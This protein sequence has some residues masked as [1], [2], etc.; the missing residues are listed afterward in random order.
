[1]R[2]LRR[3]F[4]LLGCALVGVPAGAASASAAGLFSPAPGELAVARETPAAA[5]LPDGRVLVA[6]GFGKEKELGSAEIYDPATGASEA[7]AAG[8]A[9]AHGE[10]ATVALHDGRVL[11]IGGWTSAA[12]ALRSAEVFDPVTRTFAALGAEM[13]VERD[14]PAAVVLPSG[15]V[16]IT[17][18]AQNGSKPYGRTAEIYDP[19]TGLFS[20]VKGTALSGRWEPSAALLPDGKVLIAGGYSGPPE[21]VTTKTAELFDPATETFAKL[22]G[23]GHEPA[24]AR[25][26]PGAV[27]L[28]NGRVLI[29]GGQNAEG[30]LTSAEEFDPASS[31]FSA[32]G[33][34]LGVARAADGAVML[35]DGRALFLGGLNIDFGLHERLPLKSIEVA[36]VPAATATTGTASGVGTTTAT[37]A[38]T[39]STEARA[40]VHF[41]YGT[42]AAYGSSTAGTQLGYAPGA[43][44]VAAS[45]TGLAAAQTYHFR[46]VAENAG[47]TSYGADQTFTTATSGPP[48]PAGP[49]PPRFSA[50]KQSQ[51]RWREGNALA[52]ASRAKVP[53]GTAFSFQLNTEAKLTYTLTYTFTQRVAGRKVHGRCVAPSRRNRKAPLCARTLARGALTVNGHAGANTLAFQ[54]RISSSRKLRPGTYTLVITAVGQDGRAKSQ[55]LAFTIVR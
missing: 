30:E 51:R 35:P 28:Q 31:T 45:V 55:P 37:L 38:G 46:A 34:T 15:K 1:M 8:E 41:Q 39:V 13:A 43:Q 16:F 54:G 17:G 3:S 29:A 5:L 2:A 27:T 10:Q 49:P 22:E 44:S 12:N 9:A 11:L 40:S 42:S 7:L 24:E 18:G 36:S 23:A 26:W 53:L 32:L 33:D 6:G 25:E 4:L 21:E 20:T 14:G 19:A 52:K 47:G 48:H 50:L